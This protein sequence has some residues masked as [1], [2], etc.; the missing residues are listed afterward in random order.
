MLLSHISWDYCEKID[1]NNIINHWKMTFQVSDRKGRSFLNLVD[2]NYEN[3]KPSYIK[4]DPWLQAFGYSNLLCAQATRTITNHA[5]I[6]ECHLR[7]FPNEDF[8]CPC[9]NFPIESRR[10]VLYNCKRHNGY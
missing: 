5:S 6:G 10:H 2:N 7:F 9:G 3:I 8:S 4:G 1:S